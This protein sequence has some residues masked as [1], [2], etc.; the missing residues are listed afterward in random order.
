LLLQPYLNRSESER[1][2]ILFQARKIIEKQIDFIENNTTYYGRTLFFGLL[3]KWK[4]EI[5]DLLEHKI[6]ES[7]PSLNIQVD[8]SYY[9]KDEEVFKTSIIISNEGDSTSEGFFMSVKF[10]SPEYEYDEEEILDLDVT[11]EIAA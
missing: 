6:A 9:W 2:T 1:T 11:T 10:E 5:D 3:I 4:K 8:P 7:L